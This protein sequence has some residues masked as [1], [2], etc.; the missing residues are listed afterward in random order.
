MA[1]RDENEVNSTVKW[2][3]VQELFRRT[4]CLLHLHVGGQLIR[5]TAEHP[6]FEYTKEK[7]VPGCPVSLQD[8]QLAAGPRVKA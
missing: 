1:S 7:K 3:K 2:K 8:K 4:G 5:T 6:F